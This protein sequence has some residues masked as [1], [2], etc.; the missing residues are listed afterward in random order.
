MDSSEDNDFLSYE[1]S[2]AAIEFAAQAADGERKAASGKD[3]KGDVDDRAAAAAL[4]AA[5]NQDGEAAL[6]SAD[7]FSVRPSDADNASRDE[8]ELTNQQDAERGSGLGTEDEEGEGTEDEDMDEEDLE[9]NLFGFGAD[10]NDDDDDKVEVTYKEKNWKQ[11]VLDGALDRLGVRDFDAL[12]TPSDTPAPANPRKAKSVPIDLRVPQQF[13][14]KLFGHIVEDLIKGRAVHQRMETN[15]L[16]PLLAGPGKNT[17]PVGKNKK[18]VVPPQQSGRVVLTL[19]G[20]VPQVNMLTEEE[21]L[22]FLRGAKVELMKFA[23][24]CSGSQQMN[25]VSTGFKVL[26]TLM[27][28]LKEEYASYGDFAPPVYMAELEAWL[29]GVTKLTASKKGLVLKFFKHA[30]VMLSTSFTPAAIKKSYLKSGFYPYNARQ[31]MEQCTGWEDLSPEEQLRLLKVIEE[32]IPMAAIHGKVTEA[33]Q[34]HKHVGTNLSE[35]EIAKLDAAHATRQRCLWLNNEGFLLA[36]ELVRKALEDAAK[37]KEEQAAEAKE[38]K[39]MA[40]QRKDEEKEAKQAAKEEAQ[41]AKTQTKAD[42]AAASAKKKAEKEGEAKGAKAATKKK[43]AAKADMSGTK[44]SAAKKRKREE[45]SP[46]SDEEP[47]ELQQTRGGRAV[48]KP[49]R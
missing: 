38:A 29:D 25:D 37:T 5:V 48:K 8:A 36:C 24:A 30:P 40:K 18:P 9:E 34:D 32:L 21:W 22:Q 16:S 1:P 31:I 6:Y 43:K 26:K 20:D 13:L 2:A 3:E 39:E 45:R 19:D 4:A 11:A 15:V 33:D 14:A 46:S 10:E 35:Q 23:A 49:K 47:E 17:K 27:R 42:K 7:L 12:N 28:N 41:A 44:K